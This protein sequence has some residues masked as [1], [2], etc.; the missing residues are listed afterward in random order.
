MS[1]EVEVLE[2]PNCQLDHAEPTLARYDA[3]TT[4]GPWAYLC[5]AHFQEVG[6][7]LGTGNG[8]RL[9]LRVRQ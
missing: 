8:Q 2:L 3:R 9:K 7:G 6:V 4:M 1:E 5:E